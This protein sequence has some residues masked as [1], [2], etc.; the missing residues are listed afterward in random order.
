MTAWIDVSDIQFEVVVVQA[1]T[2]YGLVPPGD[3]LKVS[4]KTYYVN[5]KISI[6]YNLN[7]DGTS[8]ICKRKAIILLCVH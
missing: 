1:S 5:I 6:K 7:G 8:N 2:K 4:K 3:W